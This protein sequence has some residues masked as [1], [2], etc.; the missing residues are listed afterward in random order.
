M[1]LAEKIKKYVFEGFQN[2]IKCGLASF[3][4]A[5]QHLGCNEQVL[6]DFRNYKSV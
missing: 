1:I 4:L 5:K 2:V 3:M 6:S